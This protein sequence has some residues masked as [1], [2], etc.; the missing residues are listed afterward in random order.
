MSAFEGLGE[1]LRRLRAR[2]GMRQSDL[3]ERAGI[4]KP[5]ISKI[6]RGV[7]RP[8]IETLERLLDALPATLRELDLALDEARGGEA[9]AR[10]G[11]RVSAEA[12]RGAAAGWSEPEVVFQA[13][14]GLG[15]EERAKLA[16]VARSFGDFLSLVGDRAARAT[17]PAPAGEK[18]GA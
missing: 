14:P 12:S 9:G 11:G 18:D 13:P 6:E 1:G 10:S 15:L 5:Q 2:R 8:N 4:S 16:E 7:Q 3:S 17:T